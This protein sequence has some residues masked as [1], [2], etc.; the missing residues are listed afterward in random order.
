MSVTKVTCFNPIA[1]RMYGVLTFLSAI[2]SL[3]LLSLNLLHSE[4][5]KLYC[6]DH[7]ECNRVKEGNFW[8]FDHSECN[9]FK[10][11]NFCD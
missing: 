6:F 8:S 10:E 7:S 2:G 11:G 9:R 5:S 4:Q 1:F 3:K